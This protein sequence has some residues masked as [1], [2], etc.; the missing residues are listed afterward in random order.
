MT[1]LG[2]LALAC[3]LIGAARRRPKLIA[4]ALG[5]GA[6]VPASAGIV[7]GAVAVPVFSCVGLVAVVSWLATRP[8]GPGSAVASTLVAFAA[9]SI[10][11]TAIGP[12]AFAGTPVLEPRGGIDE[13]IRALTPLAFGISNIAQA[14]YLVIALVVVLHLAATGTARTALS[15]AAWTGIGLSTVRNVLR[16]AGTDPLAPVFD[17]LNASYT[18]GDARLRGVF[19][20]PSELATFTLAVM[21]GTVVLALTS[22]GRR[23]I[24]PLVLGALALGNLLGS[25]SGTA[26]IASGAVVALALVVVVVRT[27]LRDGRGVVWFVLGAITVTSVLLVAGDTVTT[28]LL[29]VIE[30]KVGSQSFDSRTAADAIGL[31]VTSDTLGIGAGLGSNRSSSFLVTLLSTVGVPGTALFIVAVALV[32]RRAAGQR[33]TLPAVATLGALLIAKVVSVPDL[34]TP[35]L[36][37]TIALCMTASLKHNMWTT[38]DP[39]MIRPT[40]VPWQSTDRS[41]SA[42]RH[43]DS[44]Q[45]SSSCSRTCRRT[46]TTASAHRSS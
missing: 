45:H 24:A 7:V 34:S 21:T 26:V 41:S 22:R 10:A 16:S 4:I 20:E 36:W 31:R 8:R 13:Q 42:S 30:D 44:S 11:V 28:P 33:A 40:L 2:V 35:L 25:V 39:V 9:W 37:V 1:L 38:A 14:G 6:G 3:A 12:W 5:F 43:C 23:R 18:D 46:C 32:V 19:S 17:T 29:D 27:V 15:V